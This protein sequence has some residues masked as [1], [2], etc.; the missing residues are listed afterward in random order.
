[1]QI[2]FI[3]TSASNNIKMAD[4][5]YPR[6]LEEGKR[7]LPAF[8]ISQEPQSDRD[9]PRCE[10]PGSSPSGR[11]NYG[12]LFEGGYGSARQ[13]QRVER[14]GDRGGMAGLG[15]F[16]APMSMTKKASSMPQRQSCYDADQKR[17]PE[18]AYEAVSRTRGYQKE[19]SVPLPMNV[20]LE[21]L[22]KEL[23]SPEELLNRILDLVNEYKK[24]PMPEEQRQTGI[25]LIASC[26]R[27]HDLPAKN[28]PPPLPSKVG[29]VSVWAGPVPVPVEKS[30]LVLLSF[31]LYVG[32]IATEGS[33]ARAVAAAAGG[34][35][36]AENERT[37]QTDEV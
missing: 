4:Q 27:A 21:Q 9:L 2:R 30:G 1:M 36:R 15:T 8:A 37:R 26:C 29:V 20:Q 19:K 25:D 10:L 3:R 6:N 16:C 32:D 17:E 5:P 23:H 14:S 22:G 28:A 12:V 31:V 7:V 24:L 35:G 18:G 33:A 34:Q 13:E 11:P